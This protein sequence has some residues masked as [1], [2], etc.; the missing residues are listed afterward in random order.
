[1]VKGLYADVVFGAADSVGD[2]PSGGFGAVFVD[3][4]GAGVGDSA[5][6]LPVCV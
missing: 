4:G 6:G 1:M 2:C 5:V 3:E